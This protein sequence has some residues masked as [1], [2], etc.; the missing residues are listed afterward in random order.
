MN[1]FL[2]E[3]SVFTL[4]RPDEILSTRLPSALRSRGRRSNNGTSFPGCE[5]V[6]I[7]NHCSWIDPCALPRPSNRWPPHMN[8]RK[9]YLVASH[10]THPSLLF[11][12][13]LRTHTTHNTHTR[14]TR[15]GLCSLRTTTT[16]LVVV[17]VGTPPTSAQAY[18]KAGSLLIIR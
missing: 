6:A 3:D 18:R 12:T 14:T 2:N 15:Y 10:I 9:Q 13:S 5:I 17:F 4:W 11:D 1:I 7:S 16:S 8:T